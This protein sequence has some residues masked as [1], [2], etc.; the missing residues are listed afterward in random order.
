MALA[1]KHNVTIIMELLNSK[2]DHAD[3]MCDKSAW[4]DGTL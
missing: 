4:G 3:Y 2:V 1:E